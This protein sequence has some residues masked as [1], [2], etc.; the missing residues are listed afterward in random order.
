MKKLIALSPVDLGITLAEKVSDNEVNHYRIS[1]SVSAIQNVEAR[2]Q[3]VKETAERYFKE[4]VEIDWS[5]NW[6]VVKKGFPFKDAN[7]L[8]NIGARVF[9]R[10]LPKSKSSINERLQGLPTYPKGES[11]SA[12][13]EFVLFKI[14]T[15]LLKA[16]SHNQKL[17]AYV[18]RSF[19][20]TVMSQNPL[21][22][23]VGKLVA[24]NDRVCSKYRTMRAMSKFSTA[25]IAYTEDK[26]KLAFEIMSDYIIYNKDNMISKLSDVQTM[27]LTDVIGDGKKRK[28]VFFL[29]FLSG[30]FAQNY[31][32]SHNTYNNTFLKMIPDDES[33][34][35][36]DLKSEVKINT[37]QMENTGIGSEFLVLN[38]YAGAEVTGFKYEGEDQ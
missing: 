1:S 7:H 14:S 4:E 24:Y 23:L 11:L 37:F 21:D 31:R 27:D 15:I 35:G 38:D 32:S 10:S 8:L 19:N 6:K 17:K 13:I 29:H 36:L 28:A 2:N 5:T 22:L 25:G 12:K 9:V 34:I 16:A 30:S 26:E 3:Y 18:N 33:E 20:G